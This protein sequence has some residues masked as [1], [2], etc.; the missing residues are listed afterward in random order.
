MTNFLPFPSSESII[1]YCHSWRIFS[2]NIE[3]WVDSSFL[4]VLHKYCYHLSGL[5]IFWWEIHCHSNCFFPIGSVISFLMLS[6]LFSLPLV[7][8]SLTII[9]LGMD[10]IGLPCVKFAQLLE[11]TGLHFFVKSGKLLALISSIQ[12]LWVFFQPCP[13]SLL[14]FQAYRSLFSFCF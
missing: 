12:L 14:F 6:K 13:L 5:H 3:F 7:L 2:L 1:V 4:S 11:T 10:F 8:K 9:C